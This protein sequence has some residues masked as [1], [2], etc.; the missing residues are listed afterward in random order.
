MEIQKSSN[1]GLKY[2]FFLI[3]SLQFE[4]GSEILPSVGPIWGGATLRM[5][6]KYTYVCATMS[7][8]VTVPENIVR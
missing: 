7:A 3:F 2:R 6:S 5:P 1:F 8:Y 4:E